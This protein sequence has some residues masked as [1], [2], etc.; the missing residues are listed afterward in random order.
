VSLAAITREFQILLEK[1]R[2][3]PDDEAVWSMLCQARREME[4]AWVCEG[5]THRPHGLL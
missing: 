2:L 1:H 5:A 3:D 4:F